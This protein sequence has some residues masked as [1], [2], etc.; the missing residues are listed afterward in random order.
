MPAVPASAMAAPAWQLN[1][2]VDLHWQVMESAC[3]AFESVS[4]ETTVIDAFDAAALACL[5]EGPQ[6]VA[7]I[8]D[9]LASDLLVQPSPALQEQVL[10]VVEEFLARGWVQRLES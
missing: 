7:Q 9:A 6:D 10:G 1:P 4:G 2:L 8:T 3:V 5:E